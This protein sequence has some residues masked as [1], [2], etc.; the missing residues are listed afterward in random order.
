M[1]GYLNFFPYY[2]S[3]RFIQNLPVPENSFNE[4]LFIEWQ[5]LLNTTRKASTI[6]EARK[7]IQYSLLHLD[8][9]RISVRVHCFS[10]LTA[11]SL[12][13]LSTSVQVY[14]ENI[15]QQANCTRSFTEEI[16]SQLPPLHEH[17][18][19]KIPLNLLYKMVGVVCLSACAR[20]PGAFLFWDEVFIWEEYVL[21]P[22]LIIKS[23]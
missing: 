5:N 8:N 10:T 17:W 2:T 18:T 13:R 4:I 21:W 3:F 23:A 11:A 15:L 22:G 1:K 9:F 12:T 16:A 14:L 6:C 19:C 20:F 7:L